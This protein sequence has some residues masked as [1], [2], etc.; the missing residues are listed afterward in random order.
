MDTN[1]LVKDVKARFNINFQKQQLREKYTAK[2]IFADQGGL[3][4]ATPE[5]IGFLSISDKTH[6]VILDSYENPIRVDINQ[7]HKKLRET[8]NV[9][10]EQWHAE[11]SALEKN[12]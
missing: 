10:M 4:K 2:L 3:W 8:Y 12:R 7:L 1:Q 6:T 11:Y 9:V 5:L